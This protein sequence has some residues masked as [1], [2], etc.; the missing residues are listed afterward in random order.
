MTATS[1]LSRRDVL[2]GVT[3]IAVLVGAGGVLG[4]CAFGSEG[5]EQAKGKTSA[6]NPLGVKEDAP[7]E[8]VIFDGGFGDQY[9]KDIEELYRKQYPKAEVTHVPTQQ[10]RQ[11]QQPRFVSGNPPDV[12]NN[13]G[14]NGMDTNAL[15]EQKQLQDLTPLFDAPSIDDP[16]TPVRETLVAGTIEQGQLG[17][18]ECYTLNYTFT[19][20]GVWYS[21]SLFEK[22]GW[23]YPK[24]WDKMI[25][26]CEEIKKAGMSPWTYQGKFPYYVN[27][28]LMPMAAKIGGPDV[29]KNIDNLEPN[30]WKQDA[31][32]Q[33]VEAYYELAAKGYVLPGSEGMTHIESQT[34]WT[35]GKAVFIPNGSW[36]ENEA[37]PTTPADFQMTVAPPSSLAE[38]DKSPFEAIHAAPAIGFVVPA[39]AKNVA[40]GM[41]FI[42]LMLSKQASK[43]FVQKV[44][45]LTCVKGSA[46]GV[47]LTP[48]LSSGNEVLEAAG[49]NV[50]N[51]RY[52]GWYPKLENDA[53]AVATGLLMSNRIKPD[54][55]ISRCQ[56]AADEIAKDSN[57]KKY[58]R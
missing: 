48:G 33:A 20:F 11:T 1:T 41:E 51:Y 39:Q 27:W 19:V 14:D 50:I 17:G 13:T 8:V 40:G 57:T 3:T 53:V 28:T 54:E 44:S 15:I 56:K 55:W 26:L 21:K 24:T 37:K 36:V 38:S 52:V 12:I 9:A 49:D 10:I 34:A 42:R 46:E 30:A 43:S 23:E 22:R 58:R 29:L 35:Q 2:G 16:N 47:S 31:V 32:R 25:A 45:S 7:L 4:G 6:G 18:K 5:Q